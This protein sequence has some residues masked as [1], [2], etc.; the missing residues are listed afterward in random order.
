MDMR[1]IL[2]MLW[3]CLGLLPSL[4]GRDA[5]V[6]FYGAHIPLEY[7][8]AL[9]ASHKGSLS[10]EE[11]IVSLYQE[12]KAR[13]H[14][15][16]LM[17][18]GKAK[19][20]YQLNDWLYYQLLEKTVG[21]I[22]GHASSR[23]AGVLSWMLLA[24]SG[25]DAR[26]TFTRQDFFVNVPTQDV[27]FETPMYEVD[28]Q[29]FANLSIIYRK[30][31]MVRSVYMV[32]FIPNGRGQDFSFALEQHPRFPS[33]IQHKN[34]T[35]SH[36][37]KTYRIAAQV[38]RTLIDLMKDYPNFGEIYFVKTPL[39]LVSRNSL[40]PE[41]RKEMQGMD[42]KEKME[43]LVAFTRRGLKYGSD[44]QAFGRH[45]HPLT[46]EEALYYPMMDCEDKVAVLYNLVKELTDF[47]AVVLAMP[48]HLSFAVHL[49]KPVGKTFRHR[50]RDY[51]ICDPTGPEN[52]SDIGVFPF[53]SGLRRGE[54]L[55]EL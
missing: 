28:G 9:V 50:G 35:F 13:P 24:E 21:E 42:D 1:M 40:L 19:T 32:A 15:S 11:G 34:Y 45:N 37:G 14:Q 49:K 23:F 44:R 55:G 6:H 12:L 47:K 46:A 48:D 5:T 8:P 4:Q 36:R 3:L 18:L 29:S 25:Y 22:A 31:R 7:D 16:L 51:T 17:A 2:A 41:L 39:S 30:G 43:F 54:V 26:A 27:L 20:Q 10:E 38:D 52:T 53:P 33:Q